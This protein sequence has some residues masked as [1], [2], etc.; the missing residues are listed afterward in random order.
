MRKTVILASGIALLTVFVGWNSLAQEKQPERKA[1]KKAEQPGGESER[2][3]KESEVP[4]AALAALKKQAGGNA[5][6]EFA[7]EIEHGHKFYEGT[8][9]SAGGSVD[10][11]VTESGDLVE[12]EESIAAEQVPGGVRSAVEKEAGKDAKISYEKKT[13]IVYEAHFKKGDRKREVLMTPDGRVH[14]EEGG[15]E[16]EHAEDEDD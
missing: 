7:E 14:H 11:L 15:H 13:M 1:A 12:I 9:K 5:L 8:Y 10:V 16:G 3:V 4:A 2:Q 6:T